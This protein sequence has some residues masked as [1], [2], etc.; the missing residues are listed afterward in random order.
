M[1][2][3]DGDHCLTCSDEALPVSVVRVDLRDGLALVEVSGRQE[4]VDITLI[5]GVAPGDTLLVHGGV[6]IAR[7]DTSAIEP[8]AR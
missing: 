4:E 7:L 1:K 2:Y 3:C 6:A 8:R 5:D